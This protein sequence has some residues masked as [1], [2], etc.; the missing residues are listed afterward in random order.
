MMQRKFLVMLLLVSV[1]VMALG[2]PLMAYIY[3]NE[4]PGAYGT[5]RSMAA[6]MDEWVIRGAGLFLDGYRD[7]MAL[8]SL[9]ETAPLSDADQGKLLD[10]ADRAARNMKRASGVYAELTALA[11]ATPYNG[12]VIGLLASFDY[13]AFQKKNNLCGDIFAEVKA[14]LASGDV[15]A[16]YR[17]FLS[18]TGELAEKL[19]AIGALL[20]EGKT[21]PTERLWEINSVASRSL[22]FGQYVSQV[23]YALK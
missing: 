13:A 8:F 16:V 17:R 21:P 12:A 11:E 22:L 23:F 4:S 1:W 6:P 7:A 2:E 9:L 10:L 3:G 14:L 15:T 18:D 20:S 5:P 19:G